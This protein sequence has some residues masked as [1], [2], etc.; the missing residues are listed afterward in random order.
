MLEKVFEPY[1][2]LEYSRNRES[3]GTGLGLAIAR[4]MAAL[5]N[6]SIR[7]I[8]RREGGLLARISLPSLQEKTAVH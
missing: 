6:G 1:Y 5:N 8:N 7:L 3:G 2:R 4:N